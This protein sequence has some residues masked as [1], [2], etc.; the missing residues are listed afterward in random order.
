[1]RMFIKE[2]KDTIPDS[3]DMISSDGWDNGI[4]LKLTNQTLVK[5]KKDETY[6]I[7]LE[8]DDNVTA[9]LRID[10]LYRDKI[11]KE[12]NIYDD[13]V[14]ARDKSCY[15]YL[16]KSSDEKLRIGAY[17]FSGNPDIYV[18][19]ESDFGQDLESFKFKATEPS[20]D[21]LVITP[22]DRLEIGQKKGW[23]HIC[24]TG[25]SATSYRLRVVESNQSY[26]LEDGISET[27]EIRT[28]NELKFYYTDAALVRNLNLTFTLTTHSG[29]TPKMIAK[30]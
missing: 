16:V 5:V 24:I 25:R 7:L 8:T 23:Y 1:M 9:N 17:S 29:P 13:F 11:I 18:T 27:N 12:G 28:G 19:P 10:I 2:G 14:Y 26:F 30:F 20:D 15:K 4:V 22:Q 3:S 21:V 6:K